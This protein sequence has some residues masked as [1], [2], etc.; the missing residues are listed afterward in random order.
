MSST[1]VK[2]MMEPFLFLS[3]IFFI[4]VAETPA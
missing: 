3:G 4:I 2:A 1:K